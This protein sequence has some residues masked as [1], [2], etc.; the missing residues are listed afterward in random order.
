MEAT[1]IS[2]IGGLKRPSF[3][4]NKMLLIKDADNDPIARQ[5]DL[6]DICARLK[7]NANASLVKFDYLITPNAAPGALERLL[8]QSLPANSHQICIDNFVRCNPG[9]TIAK[10]DKKEFWANLITLNIAPVNELR[11]LQGACDF[12]HNC[13]DDVSKKI[14]NFF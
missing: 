6:T 8:I 7:A 1:A 13:W 5:K 10:T 2:L 12:N 3:G 9:S 11:K 14:N 4:I